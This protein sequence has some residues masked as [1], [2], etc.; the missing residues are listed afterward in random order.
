MDNDIGQSTKKKSQLYQVCSFSLPSRGSLAQTKGINL[1]RI[2][3]IPEGKQRGIRDERKA[4][5]KNVSLVD[6]IR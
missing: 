5:D 4:N 1:I 6:L 2:V 3:K